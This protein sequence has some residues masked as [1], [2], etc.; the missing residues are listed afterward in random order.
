MQAVL[1]VGGKGTRLRP[2]TAVFPK[3]LLPLGDRPILEVVVRQL[4]REGFTELVMAV[5]HQHEMFR[6][7]FGD[8]EKWGVRI[9]YSLEDEPLGTAGPLRRIEGLDENFLMMNGDLLTDLSYGE[10]FRNHVRHGHP[11]TLA[12]HR[13]EV[14]IDYGTLESGEDGR[15]LSYTEKPRL[16]YQ[17]SMGIYVL[18]RSVLDVVPEDRPFDFPDLVDA[19]LRDGRRV[20]CYPYNGYWLDIGRPEDYAIALEDFDRMKDRLL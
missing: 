4:R 11:A 19:L 12:I 14:R 10:L 16:H 2:Y 3:S 5:G 1:L 9:R 8:G 17:V 18:S 15:L 13:R 7:F 20:Q 6:L